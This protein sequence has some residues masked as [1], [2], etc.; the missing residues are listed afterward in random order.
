MDGETKNMTTDNM[1]D[2]R[3]VFI[4][5][6]SVKDKAKYQIGQV[7]VPASF[8]TRLLSEATGKPEKL[9]ERLFIAGLTKNYSGFLDELDRQEMSLIEAIRIMS[10]FKEIRTSK[11][12][13]KTDKLVENISKIIC[14]KYADKTVEEMVQAF[15]ETIKT[16]DFEEK[17]IKNIREMEEK[18][19]R[20]GQKKIRV[21]AFDEEAVER[22][23][24]A[25]VGRKTKT[26][27]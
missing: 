17:V 10:S 12:R 8:I 7:S 21:R 23:K 14:R 9:Q 26:K 16:A 15:F 6:E 2:T 22:A 4:K 11:I 3:I 18:F 25:R 1:Q 20:N 13:S 5:G 27:V 19:G 24:T